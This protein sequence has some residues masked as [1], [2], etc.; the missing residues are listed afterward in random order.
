MDFGDLGSAAIVAIIGAAAGGVSGVFAGARESRITRRGRAR[1][2]HEDLYRLQSTITRMYYE[3][4]D[5]AG[6]GSKSWYLNPLAD[7]EDQQDVLGHLRRWKLNTCAGALGWAEYLRSGREHDDVQAPTKDDLIKI[8]ARIAEGRM[9]VSKMGIFGLTG[10]RYAVHSPA[11]IVDEATASSG[12]LEEIP[13]KEAKKKAKATYELR[14]DPT[15]VGTK[16]GA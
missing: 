11:S 2:I 8:Y 6:W 9:A 12:G 1:L 4:E 13:A 15:G 14:A 10:F 7:K 16:R 3:R 5:E